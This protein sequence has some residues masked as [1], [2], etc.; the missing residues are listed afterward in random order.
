MYHYIFLKVTKTAYFDI[1]KET[2]MHAKKYCN[3]FVLIIVFWTGG[4]DECI[5]I[6]GNNN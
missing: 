6:L 2:L 3:K 1:F 4:L 5:T